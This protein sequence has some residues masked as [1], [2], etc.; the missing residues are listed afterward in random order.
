MTLGVDQAPSAKVRAARGAENQDVAVHPEN[1][2]TPILPDVPRSGNGK[3]PFRVRGGRGLVQIRTR[4]LPGAFKGD[5]SLDEGLHEAAA[6]ALLARL[7]TLDPAK[8]KSLIARAL[9][10]K[11]AKYLAYDL[12]V[13][14]PQLSPSFTFAT[15]LFDPRLAHEVGNLAI[16]DPE[17]LT[18]LTEV[19]TQELPRMQ[20]SQGRR[21]L[22]VVPIEVVNPLAC[23]A[24]DFAFS[25]LE[26]VLPA[27][28][29]AGRHTEVANL[30]LL[31]HVFG[32]FDA[33][34]D[35][36]RHLQVVAA[37]RNDAY[38]D[39]AKR[40]VR[41]RLDSNRPFR[42]L[43]IARVAQSQAMAH[44]DELEDELR[45]ITSRRDSA[46]RRRPR[47]DAEQKEAVAFAQTAVD[48]AE[49]AADR[50]THRIHQ[51]LALV[52]DGVTGHERAVPIGWEALA[53]TVAGPE[54][55]LRSF[56]QLHLGLRGLDLDTVTRRDLQKLISDTLAKTELHKLLQIADG[57]FARV[58]PEALLAL[59]GNLW[60]CHLSDPDCGLQAEQGTWTVAALAKL[61][62]RPPTLPP[63]ASVAS[64]PVFDEASYDARAQRA[65]RRLAKPDE[66]G[67][68]SSEHP[69]VHHAL[70]ERLAGVEAVFGSTEVVRGLFQ[71]QGRLEWTKAL[72]DVLLLFAGFGATAFC[73]A[74]SAQ[75]MDTFTTPEKMPLLAA[76]LLAVDAAAALTL[77]KVEP[78]VRLLEQAGAIDLKQRA[79]DEGLEGAKVEV[80]LIPKRLREKLQKIA[81]R[82][83]CAAAVG[84]S[85]GLF[86]GPISDFLREHQLSIQS[87][88]GSRLSDGID[89]GTDAAQTALAKALSELLKQAGA[90]DSKLGRAMAK[91][92][93]DDAGPKSPGVDPTQ[94]KGKGGAPR[95]TIRNFRPADYEVPYW[96]KSYGFYNDEGKYTWKSGSSF[97]NIWWWDDLPDG[98]TFMAEV[99]RR[100]E[101]G[102]MVSLIYEGREMEYPV[103]SEPIGVLTIGAS[104]QDEHFIPGEWS[105]YNGVRL[106]DAGAKLYAVVFKRLDE[107]NVIDRGLG[108][109]DPEDGPL[110]PPADPALLLALPHVSKLMKDGQQARDALRKEAERLRDNNKAN[111]APLAAL[112]Q[113][114]GEVAQLAQN[115]TPDWKLEPPTSDEAFVEQ[116]LRAKPKAGKAG[117]GDEKVVLEH[118]VWPARIFAP[119]VH[120]IDRQAGGNS[121][122]LAGHKDT[123]RAGDGP[124]D[125]YEMVMVNS[126]YWTH[127]L[128]DAAPAPRKAPGKP[129]PPAKDDFDIEKLL[130]DDWAMA[131]MI[132]YGIAGLALLG[133]AAFGIRRL[134]QKQKEAPAEAAVEEVAAQIEARLVTLDAPVALGVFVTLRRAAE[135]WLDP[136][137]GE[138]LFK[139]SEAERVS[140][141]TQTY[142][143]EIGIEQ[144][145][146]ELGE[147]TQGDVFALTHD[148]ERAMNPVK[149]KALAHLLAHV[150]RQASATSEGDER[151]AAAQGVLETVI[152]GLERDPPKARTNAR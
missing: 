113:I 112:A 83:L 33:D 55:A 32:K 94:S 109:G 12:N 85:L 50:A 90:D 21:A 44:L 96:V 101:A 71:I 98:K 97:S 142:L 61:L 89:R 31:G 91:A 131:K 51:R 26:E 151:L 49:L 59:A 138:P 38:P 1:P 129:Q 29:S 144:R 141:L 34:L 125:P 145:P 105:P 67:L 147:A 16:K 127:H 114:K 13:F 110:V 22:E 134:L 14:H 18:R 28:I 10:P 24:V 149:R 139:M 65:V 150:H 126:D 20:I 107:A 82:T 19:Y 58:E 130:V 9:D 108:F 124:G 69:E 39:F 92:A 103:G 37:H 86:N 72:A 6:T 40:L 17:L 79:F 87:S 27:L 47:S 137:P 140:A 15:A 53:S 62:Q 3:G 80:S 102:L 2:S 84:L 36:E 118:Q 106:N 148:E 116:L 152:A 56:E 57:V 128:I 133:G 63:A 8:K 68:I 111:L 64:G 43:E 78:N 30:L 73:Y 45:A 54:A 48:L 135:Y 74:E 99:Q 136:K 77:R 35:K 7:A 95:A 93:G 121:L 11:D 132:A 52:A 115:G 42:E 119:L 100:V 120:W 23:M 143:H 88:F 66:L 104:K 60:L 75:L 123:G 25:R 4:N 146:R 5:R 122:L 81:K 41:D 76:A 117:A 70:K 46:S